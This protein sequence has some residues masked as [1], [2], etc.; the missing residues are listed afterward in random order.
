MNDKNINTILKNQLH[1]KSLLIKLEKQ[2]NINSI[3]INTILINQSKDNIN[4]N[5]DIINNCNKMGKHIDFVEKNFIIFI[6]PIITIFNILNNYLFL[7]IDKHKM[8]N[9]DNIDTIDNINNI[10]TIDNINTIDN[11]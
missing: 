6:D 7:F 8:I 11:N 4:N 9:I 1:I 10:D 5:T 3:K 2:Q